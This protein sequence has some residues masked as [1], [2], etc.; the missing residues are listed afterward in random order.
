[1][2]T[3]ICILVKLFGVER[4]CF[5]VLQMLISGLGFNWLLGPCTLHC[6]LSHPVHACSCPYTCAQVDPA[7]GVRGGSELLLAL[8]QHRRKAGRLHFGVLLAAAPAAQA[9]TQHM[10]GAGASALCTAG[11]MPTTGHSLDE[12]VGFVSKSS[13]AKRQ[14]NI[15]SEMPSATW[16]SVPEQQAGAMGAMIHDGVVPGTWLAVGD[17]VSPGCR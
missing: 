15:T 13:A 8:A 1:M 9:G 3:Y 2:S 12:D 17:V 10:P 6:D 14:V 16:S 4:Q 5:D 7:R 11:E